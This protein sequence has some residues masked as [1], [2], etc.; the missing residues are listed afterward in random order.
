MIS[1]FR[2][3]AVRW[4]LVYL[5]LFG[6]SVGA[7]LGFVYWRTASLILERTEA[8][9]MADMAYFAGQYNE[10]GP[11]QLL[12]AVAERS[13]NTPGGV[14]QLTDFT[15]RPLAGNLDHFPE[16]S[17]DKKNFFEFMFEA[18]VAGGFRDH[19]VR[20][21]FVV[22]TGGL[23]LLAGR[24]I[25]QLHQVQGFMRQALG[26]ALVLAL[27]LGMAS[28][29]LMSRNML[30]RI[31]N[32]NKTSR[33]IRSGH[34]DERIPLK[35]SGDEFDNLARE[36]N[37]MLD[38]INHLMNEM[39]EVTD[40]IAHDLKTPLTR[41]QAGL[42][43]ALR[44]GHGGDEAIEA[45]RAGVS[46][47]DVL[48]DMVNGLLNLSRTEAGAGR[49]EMELLEIGDLLRDLAD[50]YEPAAAEAGIS[51]NTELAKKHQ[52]KVNRQIISQAVSNLLDN[53]IKYAA[54]GGQEQG[55]QIGLELAENNTRIEIIVS[56]NGPGI[57]EA[58]RERVIERFVRLDASRSQPGAGLGLSIAAAAARLHDGLLR[59]EDNSPG[60]RAVISLP[61]H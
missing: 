61:N 54:L 56:D 32:V 43:D 57:P 4:A 15:G 38:R 10:G 49:D 6:V 26:I 7:V 36:L 12:E 50:L 29:Y 5:M 42:E 13:R 44:T 22:L 53:A 39:R 27:M 60:L 14:Y 33:A 2:K 37:S 51:L 41:L 3:T 58:D 40:N 9:I 21:R 35:G 25:E 46:E 45:M 1:L 18:T 52:V 11:E 17:A 28:G 23:R 20:A 31:E 16:I 47:A 24:D 30:R 59:L 48:L 55:A 34:L 19:P 8:A